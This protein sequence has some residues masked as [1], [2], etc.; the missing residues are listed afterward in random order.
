M[1]LEQGILMSSW[2]SKWA[3]TFNELEA[4]RNY[5]FQ[6]FRWWVYFDSIMRKHSK[7][8]WAFKFNQPGPH[9]MGS[10][11]FWMTVQGIL[12]FSAAFGVI[13]SNILSDSGGGTYSLLSVTVETAASVSMWRHVFWWLHLMDFSQVRVELSTVCIFTLWLLWNFSGFVTH[14][15]WFLKGLSTL[16]I[17]NSGVAK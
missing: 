12:Y 14:C 6:W 15:E 10:F 13:D 16:C 5:A 11:H 4:R 7:H 17:L 1:H 8:T 3:Y 9:C 2:V